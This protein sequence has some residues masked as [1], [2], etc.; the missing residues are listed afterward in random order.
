MVRDHF[1]CVFLLLKPAFLQDRSSSV[2]RAASLRHDKDSFKP[3]SL[4][5]A[6]PELVL[7]STEMEPIA[8]LLPTHSH[9]RAH[10]WPLSRSFL[11]R[12]FVSTSR[13]SFK[14]L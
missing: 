6:F 7:L 10:T 3:Q 5:K 12:L 9:A 13:V 1:D 4:R 11:Q 8:N 2:S 14:V